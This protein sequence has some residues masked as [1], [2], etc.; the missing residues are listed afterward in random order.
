VVSDVS[1][2]LLVLRSPDPGRCRTFY[3]ALGLAF[4]E[5]Q[6]GSGP[7]HLAAVLPGGVV[8]EIYPTTEP[9]PIDRGGLADVRMGFTVKDMDLAL[10]AVDE[11]GGTVVTAPAPRA[12]HRIAVVADPDGRRIELTE[13]A[14]RDSVTP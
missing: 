3:E 11:H 5:E 8:L 10:A 14:S 2:S 6:H 12:T 9:G 7:A 1:L 13:P 4:S